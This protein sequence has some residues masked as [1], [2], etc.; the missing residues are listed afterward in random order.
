[1][2]IIKWILLSAVVLLI[3][4]FSLNYFKTKSTKKDF[5][6][7]IEYSI[8]VRSKNESV[9]TTEK[10]KAIYGSKMIMYFKE[11]NY[12]M[13]YFGE[14]LIAIYYLNRTNSQY[15]N[16]NGID[17]LEVY[18]MNDEVRKLLNSKF[19]K[20]NEKVLNRKCEL[21]INELKKTKN[22]YWFDKNLYTNPENFEKHKFSFINIYYE[23][24]K[25]PWLKHKYEGTNIELTYT[26]VKI[27]ESKISTDIFKL[28]NLPELKLGFE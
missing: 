5:E 28:P 23:K 9:V 16:R 8:D 21:L 13:C 2:K 26:A 18:N 7:K 3:F 24:A 6:G 12:K 19:E 15:T 1:M 17:S 4:G 27:D 10:L 11:G 25:S 22:Y 20:T 14:E